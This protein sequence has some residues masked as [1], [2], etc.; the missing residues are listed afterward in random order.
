MTT[1]R[2]RIIISELRDNKYRK[3]VPKMQ[4]GA[5][6]NELAEI[7]VRRYKVKPG[8]I[9]SWIAERTVYARSTIEAKL[10]AEYKSSTWGGR[11]KDE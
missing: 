5:W 3:A 7:A 6:I 8:K 11:K 9:A 4:V 10:K 1:F 2:E